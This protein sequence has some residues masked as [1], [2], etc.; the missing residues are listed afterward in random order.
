M[1]LDINFLKQIAINVFNTV[2]PLLGTK[3]AAEKTKRGAGGDLSMKIDLIAEKVIIDSLQ[4]ANTNILLISEELGEKYIGDPDKAKKNQSILIVDPL[5]GS[6][7]AARGVPYCSVSIAFAVGN[8]ISDIIKAVVLNLNTKDI[9]WAE[10][11]KGAYLN[12]IQLQVSNLGITEKCFFELNL[13]MR[14]LMTKLQELSPLIR[15]FYR[16]RI[17]GSSALTL[18]QI[19]KGSM[20]AFINLRHS[21]RLVDVAAGLLILKEAGGKIFS[22]DGTEIDCELSI[23]SKFPFIACNKNLE[24]FLKDEFINKRSQ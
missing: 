17:L 1:K 11:E 4:Q 8:R 23:N 6:N 20:E 19:A 22:T 12:E 10:K 14:N 2:N 15:K 16:I 21:N 5:D 3:E 9:Y 13:P 7:N 18:C 24:T